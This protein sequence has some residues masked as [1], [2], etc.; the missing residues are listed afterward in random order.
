MISPIRARLSY[1]NVMATVAVFLALGGTSIAVAQEPDDPSAE[2]PA[3]SG[4]APTGEADAAGSSVTEVTKRDGSDL[5]TDEE[6]LEVTVS[7]RCETNEILTGGGVRTIDADGSRP[8]VQS[9]YPSEDDPRTW[10][11]TVEN[12]SGN[13]SVTAVAY[14]LCA[15]R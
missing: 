15:T 6:S 12:D 1:A 14:A 3:A 5:S 8:I 2:Q 13:G 9:S 7:A 4:D 11:A 10:T